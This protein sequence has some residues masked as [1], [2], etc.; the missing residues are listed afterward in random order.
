MT[1]GINTSDNSDN[2]TVADHSSIL[3]LHECLEDQVDEKLH[4]MNIGKI[5]MI[6]KRNYMNDLY[7]QYELSKNKSEILR[8]AINKSKETISNLSVEL[9]NKILKFQNN[10]NKNVTQT[11]LLSKEIGRC[12]QELNNEKNVME[13]LNKSL[14]AINYTRNKLL[15]KINSVK[16]QED[17]LI[18]NEKIYQSQNDEKY[19]NRLNVYKEIKSNNNRQ[20]HKTLKKAKIS[21]YW[22]MEKLQSE[23]NEIINSQNKL[24]KY[25]EKNTC[26]INKEQNDKYESDLKKFEKQMANIE[27]LKNAIKHSKEIM[28]I[29][30]AR[31]VETEKNKLQRNEETKEKLANSGY[32]AEVGILLENHLNRFE[33]EKKIFEKLKLQNRHEIVK[34]LLQEQKDMKKRNEKYKYLFQNDDKNSITKI[35]KNFI[36]KIKSF[37]YNEQEENEILQLKSLQEEKTQGENILINNTSYDDQ[38]KKNMIGLEP[39]TRALYENKNVFTYTQNQ[40]LYKKMLQLRHVNNMENLKKSK[41]IVQKASGRV[42]VGP[43]YYSTPNEIVFKDFEINK[44]YSINVLLTNISHTINYVK[45]ENMTENLKDFISIEFTPPG[46]MSAGLSCNMVVNFNPK[47]E[48]DIEGAINMITQTGPIDIIVKCLTQKCMLRLH[49]ETVNFEQLVIDNKESK[50]FKICNDGALPTYVNIYKDIGEKTASIFDLSNVLTPVFEKSGTV[51]SEEKG[52]PKTNYYSQSKSQSSKCKESQKSNL[53]KSFDSNLSNTKFSNSNSVFNESENETEKSDSG[54]RDETNELNFENENFFLDDNSKSLYVDAYSTVDVTIW[55]KP[56][57]VGLHISDFIVI[58]DEYK[59][60]LSFTTRGTSIDVPVWTDR[61]VLNFRICTLNRLFQDTITIH[62]RAKSAL[63]LSFAFNDKLKKYLEVL[64][65]KGYVQTDNSFKAQVKFTPD[66]SLLEL[67]EFVDSEKSSFEATITIIVPNQKR[68]VT[69]KLIAILTTC[70][71]IIKPDLIDFGHCTVDESVIAPFTLTNMSILPQKYGFVN[72][73]SYLEVQPNDGFG[74][75]LPQQEMKLDIILTTKGATKYNY[76]VKIKNLFNRCFSFNITG[77]GVL[78][79]L[80]FS[81][82]FIKFAATAVGDI[83]TEK[84]HLINHHVSLNQF[85]HPLPR[86][87]NG[88]PLPIG[89]I[90]Y[91]FKLEKDIPISISPIVGVIYPK[92]E[93][94]IRFRFIPKILES[95]I[96]K[97]MVL[98]SK[99]SNLKKS[100]LHKSNDNLRSVAYLRLIKKYEKNVKMYSIPCF[101]TLGDCEKGDVGKC[102]FE[103]TLYVRLNCPII[104]P[105]ITILSGGTN[106]TVDFEEIPIGITKSKILTIQNIN[107]EVIH[108]HSS[109]LNPT[110]PFEMLNTLS[111]MMPNEIMSIKFNFH[112]T[113]EGKYQEYFKMFCKNYSINVAIKAECVKPFLEISLTDQYR[114]GPLLENDYEE[115]YFTICNKSRLNTSVSIEIASQK[116]THYSYS[117]TLPPYIQDTVKCKKYNVGVQNYNGTPVFDV[118]PCKIDCLKAGEEKTLCLSFSADH[119]SNSY[120]DIMKITLGGQKESIDINLFGKV[121]SN[122]IY[123]ENEDDDDFNLDEFNIGKININIPSESESKHIVAKENEPIVLK[124]FSRIENNLFNHV[125]KNII[126]GCVKS[127]TIAKKTGDWFCD[128]MNNLA[129]YGLTVDNIKG[130]LEKG[131][132]Q[133]IKISWNP[134]INTKVNQEINT[135]FNISCKSDTTNVYKIELVCLVEN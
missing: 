96:E 62:N 98:I 103:H 94:T 93:K 46:K 23:K 104:R 109:I 126:V 88:K 44:G 71:I 113:K 49:K 9:K 100:E 106:N 60:K 10:L 117:Q 1:I 69:F 102:L 31:N 36:N 99:E 107:K 50:I 40:S 67:K 45:Y 3:N 90:S 38:V 33:Q 80:R 51:V 19:I 27:S 123:L 18:E 26:R 13:N 70:D 37:Q 118:I 24:Q 87:A 111:E 56:N 135:S 85:T 79:P 127:S 124:L 78:P 57:F 66:K 14:D 42:L 82:N 108:L 59:Q 6:D 75:L 28:N 114:M 89:P 72:L 17:E 77:V 73:P 128:N 16:V 15:I 92:C 7:D 55:W 74:T 64:P 22:L 119:I 4:A 116:I 95:D 43:A 53:S 34:N 133:K 110:G 25:W 97:E 115:Q 52:E 35:K 122:F 61:D 130:S 134:P 8:T 65:T 12:E 91:E 129:N 81:Y 47:I 32:D 20:I 125:S 84:V 112:P 41:I 63:K 131:Q 48:M 29:S 105:A 132:E 86:I 58:S 68:H 21:E 54:T 39:E 2:E 30:R 76:L 5:E 121:K 101:I 120:A 83:C 11:N